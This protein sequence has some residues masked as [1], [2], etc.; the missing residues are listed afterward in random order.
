MSPKLL[1]APFEVWL[2]RAIVVVILASACAGLFSQYSL[3]ILTVSLI[4]ALLAFGQDIAFGLA[5]QLVLCEGAFFGFGAYA[6][7]LLVLKAGMSAWSA[8]PIATI[9][10]SL[11]GV[12]VGVA[13]YRTSGH[14]LAMLTLS[15]SMI[16]YELALNWDWLTGGAMG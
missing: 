15:F 7:A 5:G 10:T 8:I 3:H 9:A 1:A 12:L 4:F 6:S 2:S 16:F 13:S 14:Y 11:L